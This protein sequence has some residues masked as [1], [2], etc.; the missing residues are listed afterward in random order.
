MTN[1]QQVG[2]FYVCDVPTNSFNPIRSLESCWSTW[3]GQ[4][5]AEVGTAIGVAQSVFSGIWNRFWRLEML[6]EDRGK[7]VDVQQRQ[8]KIVI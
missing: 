6:A 5:L 8:T 3:R 1:I 7:V 2:C 4:L